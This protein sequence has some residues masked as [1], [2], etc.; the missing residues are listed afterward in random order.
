MV[1]EADCHCSGSGDL[2]QVTQIGRAQKRTP[3]QVGSPRKKRESVRGVLDLGRGHRL[4]LHNA[5][6]RASRRRDSVVV[7]ACFGRGVSIYPPTWEPQIV[8]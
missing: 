1:V 3:M 4:G 8:C 7:P 5:V 2:A 6:T